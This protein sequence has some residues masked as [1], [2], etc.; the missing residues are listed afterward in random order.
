MQAA[1]YA[2]FCMRNSGSMPATLF[3]IGNDGPMMFMPENLRDD[4]AKDEFADNARLICISHNASA[5]VMAMEAWMKL[6][7]PGEKLDTT[8]M[9]SEAFD[10]QEVIVLMGEDRTRQ[11]QQF[12]HIV[13]SSNGKFFGLNE[14]EMPTVDNVEGRFAGILPDQIPDANMQ[15]E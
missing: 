12:L 10:R 11:K 15:A 3:L 9:P 13:R 2:E 4:E 8:E 5:C 7:K 1:H 14:S 6:A